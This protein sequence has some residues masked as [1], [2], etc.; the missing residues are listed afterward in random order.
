MPECNNAITQKAN[1]E[2]TF[3][4]CNDSLFMYKTTYRK[5]HKWT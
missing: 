1:P 2:N 3:Q 5:A 4:V